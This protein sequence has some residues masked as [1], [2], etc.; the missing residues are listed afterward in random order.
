MPKSII[1]INYNITSAVY[2]SLW[3]ITFP[4]GERME[5]LKTYEAKVI[6]SSP[7]LK[8]NTN[9]HANADGEMAGVRVKLK[10]S[11]LYIDNYSHLSKAES[12][13]SILNTYTHKQHHTDED[14]YIYTFWN[15]NL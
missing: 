10:I 14:G 6:E 12:K 15:P 2:L 5:V 11:Q 1:L 7:S 9:R 3:I 4:T 13:Q 8:D